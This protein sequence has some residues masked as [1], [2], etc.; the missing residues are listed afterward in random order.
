MARY[1]NTSVTA[2]TFYGTTF[3]PGEEHDVP[4]FIN[5]PKMIRVPS[6]SRELP[7]ADIKKTPVAATANKVAEDKI[8]SSKEINKEEKPDGSDNNK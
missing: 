4:G 7:K 8:K 5:D 6:V 3:K 2:K 1:K